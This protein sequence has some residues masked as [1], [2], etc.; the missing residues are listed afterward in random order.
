MVKT[1]EE[2][3]RTKKLL[4]NKDIEKTKEGTANQDGGKK[5]RML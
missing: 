5:K 3:K 2:P 1:G 4:K